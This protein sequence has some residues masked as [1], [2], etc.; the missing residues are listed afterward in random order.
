M[1]HVLWL[2]RNAIKCFVS[3][4]F[5]DAYEALLLIKVHICYPHK[6]IK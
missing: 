6:R 4:K 1:R 2:F 5:E 3:G